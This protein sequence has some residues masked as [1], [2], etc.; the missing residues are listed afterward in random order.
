[1]FLR[2][3]PAPQKIPKVPANL[4]PALGRYA[5]QLSMAAPV[6]QSKIEELDGF[7]SESDMRSTVVLEP[8]DPIACNLFRIPE[9]K[10]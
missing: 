10:E 3:E 6:L 8:K 7:L 1:V 9:L 5:G 2:Q 4:P